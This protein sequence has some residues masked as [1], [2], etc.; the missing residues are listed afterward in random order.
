MG[1]NSIEFGNEIKKLCKKCVL[2]AYLSGALVFSSKGATVEE[3]TII[4]SMLK[5]NIVSV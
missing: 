1:G 4:S 5:A 2:Y 3:R